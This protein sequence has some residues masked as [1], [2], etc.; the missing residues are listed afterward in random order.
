MKDRT[1][2]R[3]LYSQKNRLFIATAAALVAQASL[4]F[5]ISHIIHP[6]EALETNRPAILRIAFAPPAADIDTSHTKTTFPGHEKSYAPPA[7]QSIPA[8]S[9]TD[10]AAVEPQ[11]DTSPTSRNPVPEENPKNT[12]DGHLTGEEPEQTGNPGNQSAETSALSEPGFESLSEGL[13]LPLPAYPPS[14]KRWNQEGT[15]R[16]EIHIAEDGSVIKAVVVSSSGYGV[17]DSA[18]VRTVEQSWK[19][20]PPGKTVTIAKDFAFI[21]D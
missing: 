20:N 5:G 19:F 21:L 2:P 10:P 9:V 7:G 12:D 13:S 17:L 1:V 4:W 16:L 14:A 15:V 18:A 8:G 3:N 11:T 6:R